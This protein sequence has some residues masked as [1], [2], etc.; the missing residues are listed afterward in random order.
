MSMGFMVLMLVGI[1]T[2]F[3][4]GIVIFFNILMKKSAD[5]H[6][7]IMNSE[8][9]D[10]KKKK[11]ELSQKLLEIEN[12]LKKRKEEADSVALQ[13]KEQAQK[14]ADAV[15]EDAFKKAKAESEDIINKAH[16]T[17]N[18]VHEDIGKELEAKTID[19]CANLL[20]ATLSKVAQDAIH[21]VLIQ[22]FI[23]DLS[24]ADLT[25]MTIDSQSIDLLTVKSLN[26]AERGQIVKI[27]SDKLKKKIPLEEKIDE[28][29]LGGAI[30]KFGSLNLDGS[31]A[32]KIRDAALAAKEKIEERV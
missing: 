25:K 14:E 24:N 2:P 18:K 17:I 11:D 20:K 5:S 6:V 4:V 15:K 19:Y 23:N 28:S 26:E 21:S 16:K 13:I 1:M 10:I 31:L 30:L 12:E 3:F 27:I 29:L 7:N 22:E 8:L 9:E 32:T